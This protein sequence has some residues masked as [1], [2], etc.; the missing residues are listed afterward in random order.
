[1]LNLTFG[2][3]WI[4]LGFLSGAALGMGFH[5]DTFMGGYDSWPRRMTRLGHIAFFGTGFLNVLA[6][7]TIV[8]LDLGTESLGWSI[9]TNAL[10]LGAISMPIC[11]FIA[12]RWKRAKPIFILPVVSL[13]LAGVGFSL[14][15]SLISIAALD[16]V[17]P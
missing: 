16:G 5:K 2:W 8:T 4:T 7:L 1:M 10:I 15:L 14:L 12:A 17:W 13:T 6:G 9:T 11:C 3:L